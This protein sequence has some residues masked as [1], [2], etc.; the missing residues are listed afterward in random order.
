[1]RA[2]APASPARRR[3]RGVAL[4]GLLT[5]L[6]YLGAAL[7]GTLVSPL[8]LALVLGV[9]WRSLGLGERGLGR[10]AP[11]VAFAAGPLLRLGIVALGVRLDAR[12]LADL[13]P[14]MLA[15]SLLGVVAAFLAVEAAGRAWGTAPDLRA[16]MGIGTAICGASAIVAA[17]PVWRAR[18]EHAATS[19]AAISLVGTVGVLA[20]AAW[21]ALAVVPIAVFAALAGAT[22]QEVGQVIAAGS[23]RGP[24]GADLA[25]LVKLSRVVLLAPVL[26]AFGAMARAS[27]RGAAEGA[28]GRPAPARPPLVPPFVLGFLALGG[29]V[30]IGLIPPSAV[31][32]VSLVGS[33]LTAAAM[34]AIGLG[35]DV[36]A[37][38]GTGATA[39]GLGA[40][41]MAALTATMVLFYAW[42]LP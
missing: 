41:G 17:A 6:A 31:A 24:E 10:L 40:I 33:L 39:L 23:V 9:L 13:G 11:G 25:L 4:V 34:A 2:P 22:L 16:L 20:F 15:G 28:P 14:A 32:A 7:G 38:R 12:L 27:D 30:S 21:D 37:V 42:I 19:V 1:M 35:V 26:I 29:A 8:L 5:A 3:L 18:H 36:R